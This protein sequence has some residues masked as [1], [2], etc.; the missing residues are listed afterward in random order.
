MCNKYN[1]M[2]TPHS[3]LQCSSKQILNNYKQLAIVPSKYRKNYRKNFSSEQV[4]YKKLILKHSEYVQC[5][6]CVTEIIIDVS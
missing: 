2:L 5:M 3:L 1:G 4:S 6:H